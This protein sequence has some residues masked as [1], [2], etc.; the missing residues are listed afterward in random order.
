MDTVTTL[1]H[2]VSSRWLRVCALPRVAG[3]GCLWPGCGL[4]AAG[5]AAQSYCRLPRPR[6]DE[7]TVG[8]I[9]AS[10]HCCLAALLTRL[11]LRRCRYRRIIVASAP[12]RCT[13]C[14]AAGLVQGHHYRAHVAEL[15]VALSFKKPRLRGPRQLEA[16]VPIGWRLRVGLHD[17]ADHILPR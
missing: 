7:A 16:R 2:S 17:L 13:L 11:T 3:R 14:A 8:A 1:G 5:P 15:A 10:T 12:V 9:I 4:A 6:H